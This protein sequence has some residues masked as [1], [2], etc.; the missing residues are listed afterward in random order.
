MLKDGWMFPSGSRSG[1]H[2]RP[3]GPLSWSLPWAGRSMARGGR[4]CFQPVKMLLSSGTFCKGSEQPPKP[5]SVAGRPLSHK[6]GTPFLSEVWWVGGLSSPTCPQKVPG[7]SWIWWDVLSQFTVYSHTWLQPW[8]FYLIITSSVRDGAGS[9]VAQQW[10][11]NPSFRVQVSQW[12]MLLP[13]FTSEALSLNS[14]MVA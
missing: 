2:Q 12:V 13:L 7:L 10:G 4:P 11:W 3:G 5:L 1:S 6:A 14:L 8:H 9:P